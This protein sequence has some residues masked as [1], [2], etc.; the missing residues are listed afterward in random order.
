M[1]LISLNIE[2]F[3]VIKNLKLSFPDKII[4]I[5]GPN[6]SGKSSIIESIA[7]VLY[8]NQAARSGKDEIK[9]SFVSDGSPTRVELVFTI[10]EEKYRVVRTISGKSNK[11]DV[12]LYR[13]DS[14]ESV[15]VSETKGYIGELLGLDWKGFLSSFLARQQELNALSDLQPSK[16]KDHLAGMLGIEKLDT[17]I[18]LVKQDVKLISKET[19][20]IEQQLLNLPELEKNIEL[21]TAKIAEINSSESILK[22]AYEKSK[23]DL[24]NLTNAFK[25][26]QEKKNNWV[27]L[28]STID[29][30]TRTRNNI[31]E[32]LETNQNEHKYLTKISKEALELT[33]Q[34]TDF[35]KFKQEL[36]KLNEAKTKTDIKKQL[37]INVSNQIKKINDLKINSEQIAKKESYKKQQLNSFP[38]NLETLNKNITEKL[39][40]AREN[41][42]ELKAK[43]E[44]VLTEMEKLNKQIVSIKELGKDSVCDRCLRPLGNDI[45]QIK[46]HLET[47]KRELSEKEKKQLGKL[48]KNIEQGKVLKKESEDLV[49]KI[50]LKTEY[51]FDLKNITAEKKLILSNTEADN[52]KLDELEKELKQYHEVD[53]DD[54]LHK[55]LIEKVDKIQKIKDKL[56][57]IEGQLKRLPDLESEIKKQKL[58]KD[59]LTKE[60]NVIELEIKKIEYS[61]DKLLALKTAFEEAQTKFDKAK[62]AYDTTKNEVKVFGKELEGKLEQRNNLKTVQDNL[63]KKR[64][65][66]Y[67]LEKLTSLFNEY[68]SFLIS[69]IRPTLANL[70]GTLISDM[71]NGKYNMI[72]LDDKYNLQILDYGSYFGVERFSG[73]EKDLANLCLRMAISLSLTEAAGMSSS[74][75]ILDEVFSSQDGER[76]DLII[77]ALSN[78][79]NRFPQIILVTHLEDI[80]DKVEMLI[81]VEPT[82]S[83]WSEIKVSGETE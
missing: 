8:G 83:G 75:I 63:D 55:S 44:S 69:N 77:K 78:L 65:S 81:Q 33:Q 16:R 58:Q 36:E 64:F 68:R 24:S 61:E 2:N 56:N 6:G 70:S 53:Y 37:K 71:T 79:K 7:W 41:Y 74:F 5:I 21:L 25:E 35:G 22:S 39:E 66:H 42:S 59:N 1:R 76:R 27:K 28:S 19:E 30:L 51:E 62:S 72:E 67:H 34:T 48:N 18:N 38:E 29:S 31:I 45:V 23:T 3:R 14:S 43:H 4:G 60:L 73:G 40:I 57:L 9:S 10:N 80:K 20:F 50:K 52:K 13:G 49:N 11:A 47:E 46:E 15:G 32:S 17:A 54:K 12:H 82:S 26:I